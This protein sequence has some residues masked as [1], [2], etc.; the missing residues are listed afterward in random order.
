[1]IKKL[2]LNFLLYTTALSAIFFSDFIPISWT[3]DLFVHSVGTRSYTIFSVLMI[4]LAGSIIHNIL[5]HKVISIHKRHIINYVVT[6]MKI[7]GSIVFIY[8]LLYP[9]VALPITLLIL[10]FVPSSALSPIFA[11][12]PFTVTHPDSINSSAFLLEV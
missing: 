7:I 1:M 6:N 3:R 4:F 2:N 10:I 12:A 9:I 5:E 8:L 11:I